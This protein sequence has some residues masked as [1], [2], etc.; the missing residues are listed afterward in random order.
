ML[1]LI[2]Y[3]WNQFT[4]KRLKLRLSRILSNYVRQ[5][6]EYPN[7]LSKAFF[8]FVFWWL[9]KIFFPPFWVKKLRNASLCKWNKKGSSKFSIPSLCHC[10]CH[11]DISI[12]LLYSS[13]SWTVDRFSL[14]SFKSYYILRILF[15]SVNEPVQ[16]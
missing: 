1:L 2:L 9:I 10:T 5:I 8:F 12:L 16:R 13:W 3:Y 6:S 7:V 4:Q 15:S 11:S 14:F